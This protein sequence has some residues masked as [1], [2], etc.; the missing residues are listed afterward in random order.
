MGEG[1]ARF[2]LSHS[3]VGEFLEV[4]SP[5]YVVVFPPTMHEEVLVHSSCGGSQVV[6][7]GE[8]DHCSINVVQ[9]GVVA[10]ESPPFSVGGP[11]LSSHY[12]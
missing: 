3:V 5:R 2:G 1:G 12:L 6:V 10:K 11:L 7:V 9:V 4:P 8:V